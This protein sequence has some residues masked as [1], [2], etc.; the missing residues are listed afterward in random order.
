MALEASSERTWT[1]GCQSVVS[2]LSTRRHDIGLIDHATGQ[3][4]KIKRE[5]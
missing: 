1:F 3:W 5:C 4:W 2:P